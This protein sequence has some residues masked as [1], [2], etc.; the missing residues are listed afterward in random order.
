MVIFAIVGIILTVM[1]VKS[2][3]KVAKDK[4]ETDD[5][6]DPES[7]KGKSESEG[8]QAG[9]KGH[10]AVAWILFLLLILGAVLCSVEI[11]LSDA[12]G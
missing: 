5:D 11:G 12:R 8:S 1:Y 3:H 7:G 10:P 2:K 4:Y 9:Q 6:K